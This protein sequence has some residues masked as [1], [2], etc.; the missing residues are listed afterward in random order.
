MARDKNTYLKRHREMVKKRKAEEKRE[1]RRRKK[2]Q[3]D[4][5][6]VPDTPQAGDS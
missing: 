2:E 4:E 6:A 1:Q 3:T 5:Q